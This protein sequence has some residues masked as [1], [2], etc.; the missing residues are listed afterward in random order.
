MRDFFLGVESKAGNVDGKMSLSEFGI[1]ISSVWGEGAVMSLEKP[2]LKARP[3]EKAK[4]K[5]FI[6]R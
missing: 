2:Q 3:G 6:R 4:E 1:M 5:S